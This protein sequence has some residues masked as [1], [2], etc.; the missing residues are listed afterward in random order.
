MKAEHRKIACLTAYDA[1]FAQVLDEMGVDVILVG[2]SLATVI[3]GQETTVPVTVDDM[4]YHCRCVTRRARRA[5][6]ICDMPFMSYHTV[7]EA[8]INATRMMQEGGAHVVKLEAGKHQ[9]EIVKP[10]CRQRRAV[11]CA[12]WPA[13]A[14]DT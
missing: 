10:A 4:V 6:V 8:L 14:M 5:L 7:G 9:V 12:S 3:Q 2:D 13:S 11:L 1:S